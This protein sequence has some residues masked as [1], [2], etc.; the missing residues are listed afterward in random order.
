MSENKKWIPWHTRTSLGETGDYMNSSGITNGEITFYEEIERDNDEELQDLCDEL[1][2]YADF[3]A[4]ISKLKS[5]K[6]ELI[7]ALGVAK[8]VMEYQ[9]N[10]S[11]FSTA[12]S[13][14][15]FRGAYHKT[16]A[17]LKHLNTN[18]LKSWT[19]KID[20]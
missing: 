8:E 9:I 2:N 3:K 19:K 6:E 7:E 13:A 18:P 4:E 10:N 11:G 15:E 16:V 14:Q 12:P 20:K 1:N 17:T 5:D